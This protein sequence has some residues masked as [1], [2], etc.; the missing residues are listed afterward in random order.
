FA[1]FVIEYDGEKLWVP[2]DSTS[3][4]QEKIIA[5]YYN[6]NSEF[7]SILMESE[8]ETGSVLTK[9]GMD[10]L[11]ELDTITMAVESDGIT[12]E[13][14]PFRGITRF[15]NN[16]ITDY[17]ASVT[18]DED[19][20]GAVNVETFPDGQTVNPL[21]LF[22]DIVYDDNGDISG[23]RAMIQAYGLASDTDDDA[24]INDDVY[25]WC[26]EFQDT[27]EERQDDFAD[28]VDVFY[29]TS[30]STD[31]A[32]AEAVAGELFLF[33]LTYVIMVAFVMVALGRCCTG[34]VKRRSWLGA[35][36]VVIVA[37]AGLAAYGLNS[38]FGV[39]FTSLAQILPFIL[40]GIGV[41]DMFVIVAAYDHT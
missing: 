10:V 24:D 26:G 1:N 11:W 9:A 35:G 18:S 40:I 17:E 38:A 19:V 30:R 12:Y 5:E 33:V 28:V 15:W 2:A 25:D 41:D 20:V 21:A 31:D 4:N 6:D 36:G 39:P 23:A 27:M 34:P 3:K 29:I 16:N 7:A 8:S 22:G 32:L 13:D 37:G 14:L